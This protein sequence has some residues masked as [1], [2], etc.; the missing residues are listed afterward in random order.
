MRGIPGYLT[1]VYLQPAAESALET[2]PPAPKA[3]S[4][5]ELSP[6]PM[7]GEPPS[8]WRAPLF[9]P[10]YT[11]SIPADSMVSK[12]EGSGNAATT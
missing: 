6:P 8:P 10:P 11:N 7:T 9:A 3:R 5:N 2:K 12:S 4:G 1:R